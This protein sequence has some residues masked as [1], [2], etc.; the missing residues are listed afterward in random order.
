ML[1]PRM[2]GRNFLFVPGP[3]NVP[4]RVMRAMMVRAGLKNNQCG[5]GRT[6][7]RRSSSSSV[8]KSMKVAIGISCSSRSSA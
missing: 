8:Q 3:T 5:R 6:P 1:G 2:P 7:C 4:D